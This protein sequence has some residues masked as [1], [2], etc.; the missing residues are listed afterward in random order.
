ME[1]HP[2]NPRIGGDIGFQAMNK[3]I[4][5]VVELVH[6]DGES[7]W[8]TIVEY[9]D[10][11]L[12]IFP[13]LTTEE[14]GSL[15]LTAC[16]YNHIEIAPVASETLQAFINK[17]GFVLPGGLRFSESGRVKIIPGCCSGLED[18]RQWLDVPHGSV[19]AVRKLDS[20]FRHPDYSLCGNLAHA[21][22][23]T[24]RDLA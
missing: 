5:A 17:D 23:A 19:P 2:H 22:S 3:S 15:V 11:C 21:I 18:W 13:G 12:R 8:L 20:A 14:I 16:L 1:R 6:F 7:P 4:E 24:G 10:P 9:P